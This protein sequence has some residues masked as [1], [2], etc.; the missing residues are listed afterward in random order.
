MVETINLLFKNINLT[1]CVMDEIFSYLTSQNI[2]I[3]ETSI[4]SNITRDLV[5]TYFS[6]D[7]ILGLDLI[8]FVSESEW[9][10][11]IMT[12]FQDIL[13]NPK[14]KDSF[15]SCK[16]MYQYAHY[17]Q[18]S[19]AN[20]INI[21]IYD[22]CETYDAKCDRWET[23]TSEL[24]RLF[25]G[26]VNKISLDD[27]ISSSLKESFPIILDR[28]I[29]A[30][31][32]LRKGDILLFDKCYHC[33]IDQIDDIKVIIKVDLIND[34]ACGVPKQPEEFE[35]IT[36]FPLRY[37][38]N[39]MNSYRG[40]ISHAN[41]IFDGINIDLS[42]FTLKILDI[43]GIKQDNF[44]TIYQVVTFI[45][46]NISYVVVSFDSKINLL[47]ARMVEC[48]LYKFHSNEILTLLEKEKIREERI[49]TIFG[50]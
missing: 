39:G 40:D 23:L 45:Y 20:V 15:E 47:C 35:V 30:T 29:T 18:Y 3:L 33:V 17:T 6:Y 37:W 46:K 27:L 49:L 24:D 13:F 16:D 44:L 34:Y 36:N 31:A 7:E 42:K 11:R 50:D 41:L 22:G 48:F 26:N 10:S 21:E 9:K 1:N 43:S 4:S 25:S 8:N 28:I 14:S 38:A 2:I 32:A 12:D 5:I 19:K